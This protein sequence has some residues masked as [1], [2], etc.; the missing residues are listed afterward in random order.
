M[1]QMKTHSTQSP[2]DCPVTPLSD[3]ALKLFPEFMARIEARLDAGRST[4]GDS[5]FDKSDDEL[6]DEIMQELLDVAGWAFVR[7]AKL[8][9]LRNK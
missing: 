3:E 4:Y 1:T 5:S 2:S 9:L 7:Y 6:M 8:K